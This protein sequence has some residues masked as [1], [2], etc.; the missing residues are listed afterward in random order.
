ME[1]TKWPAISGLVACTVWLS[2]SAPT[3]FAF[4]RPIHA[5]IFC[6]AIAAAAAFALSRALPHDE[7]ARQRS[8]QEY[9][10]IPLDP[11]ASGEP[12]PS[13]GP[14]NYPPSLRKL[15][16]VFLVLV[17]TIC[18]R[19]ELWRHVVSNVQC[20]GLTWEPLLPCGFALLDYWNIQRH[21]KQVAYEDPNG[22][23]Y[24]ELIHLVTMAPY[25]YLISTALL[26]VGSIV[27]LHTI[28]SPRSTYIC[29]ATLT[30][31]WAVPL[32]QRVG[33]LLDAVI[34]YSLGQLLYQQNGRGARSL[35][36]R[37]TSVGFAFW[38]RAH[39]CYKRARLMIAVLIHCDG[40]GWRKCCILRVGTTGPQTDTYASTARLIECIQW[41]ISG[42]LFDSLH[43]PN[44]KWL[45][46]LTQINTCS[47]LTAT[48]H[49]SN[50]DLSDLDLRLRC[51]THHH[52]RMDQ[53]PCVPIRLGRFGVACY[54][55][56]H[57]RLCALR[58]Y[59]DCVR[60]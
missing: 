44:C 50:N 52:T 23:A 19:V 30:N 16:I 51:H 53:L 35:R 18:A 56:N 57:S 10:A 15:R 59:E 43:A 42:Q 60:H 28:G 27:A 17:L 38:V 5:G 2:R 11:H 41:C 26:G 47:I 24:D 33:T 46:N 1:R 40:F 36:L 25:R 14:E 54:V 45:A 12:S 6:L 13:R 3:S 8:N 20:G 39:Q 48:S 4:D 55:Y 31:R 32:S 9:D 29:A 21:R 37:F 22:S 58:S 34:L 7:E 49:Q